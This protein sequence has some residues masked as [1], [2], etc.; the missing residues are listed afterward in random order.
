VASRVAQWTIDADNVPVV[1]QFWA[2]A[3][4]YRVV[5][6]D[7]GSA[8]LYPPDAAAAEAAT[9]WIQH[10]TDKK[11]HKNRAHPD[12]RPPDDDVEAEVARLV[13]LGARRVDI[14]QSPS[15]PYVVLADPAGNEFCVLRREPRST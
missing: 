11:Q 14:G 3:L 5:V 12:L 10:T 8:K 6:G 1:A 13:A 9:M 7:D 4:G 2:G 15:D